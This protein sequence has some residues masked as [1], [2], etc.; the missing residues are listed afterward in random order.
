[1]NLPNIEL[2]TELNEFKA[3]TKDLPSEVGLRVPDP[4]LLPSH[5]PLN[6][7]LDEGPRYWK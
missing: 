3:F 7:L 2:G 1:M 5:P 6:L 4:A